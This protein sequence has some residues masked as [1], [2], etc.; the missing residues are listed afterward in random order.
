MFALD[1]GKISDVVE[2]PFGFHVIQMVER[3][4]A[5]TVPFAEASVQIREFMMQRDQEARIAAFIEDLRAKSDVEI[6]I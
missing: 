2:T 6:L 4:A 5:R 1:P 3:E